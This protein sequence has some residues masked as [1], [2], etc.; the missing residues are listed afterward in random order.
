[1][2]NLARWG[3]IGIFV[4]VLAWGNWAE[5]MKIVEGNGDGNLSAGYSIDVDKDYLVIGAPKERGNYGPHDGALYIFEKN[6]ATGKWI[7]KDHVRGYFN[8]SLGTDVAV[9]DM[10]SDGVYVAAGGPDY[11]D[12]GTNPGS[13]I[14][15]DAIEIY[16]MDTQGR[17]RYM[18]RFTDDNGSGLGSSVDM[19]DYIEISGSLLN[20]TTDDKGILIVAGE[21]FSGTADGRVVTYA[22]SLMDGNSSNWKS[23][24]VSDPG[25]VYNHYG[26]AV[27]VTHDNN[28]DVVINGRAHLAV[29]APDEDVRNSRG[30]E[31]YTDKGAVYVYELDGTFSG[32]FSWAKETR[33]TQDVDGVLRSGTEYA[34]DSRFGISVDLTRWY[35]VAGALIENVVSTLTTTYVGEADLFSLQNISGNGWEL[36]ATFVQPENPDPAVSE[37]FGYAVAMDGQ[38][39]I[40]VGAP[41]FGGT[42]AVFVFGYDTNSSDWREAGTIVG[43]SAGA[44][45]S[46]VDTLDGKV[47]AGDP[48]ND[49]VSVFEWKGPNVNP[50]LLMYLLN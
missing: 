29:G 18:N 27:A 23:F 7:P 33:L 2:K 49:S 10:G 13:T 43:K 24:T 48:D 35:L 50:A 39:M 28:F 31:T 37:K 16:S 12:N 11:E 22:F 4:P 21:P 17:F 8:E 6:A 14:Y 34:D 19:A 9:V 36:N 15:R 3:V 38:K 32:G 45:G 41:D 44:L 26:H 1:M 42:G 20:H 25:L 5:V 46:S 30:T 40:T 47:I